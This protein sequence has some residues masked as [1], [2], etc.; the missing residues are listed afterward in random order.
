MKIYHHERMADS[1]SISGAPLIPSMSASKADRIRGMDKTQAIA[2]M[3]P[4]PTTPIVFVCPPSFCQGTCVLEHGKAGS[5][6]ESR[7][8]GRLPSVVPPI[9]AS[10]ALIQCCTNTTFDLLE[11]RQG[12]KPPYSMHLFLPDKRGHTSTARKRKP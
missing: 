4:G 5:R 11:G 8:S 7:I 12:S 1:C 9:F 3:Y 2:I 10:P 6:G